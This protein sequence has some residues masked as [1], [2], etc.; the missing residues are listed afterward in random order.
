VELLAQ[1]KYA[2]LVLV[3]S[4]SECNSADE[5]MGTLSSAED[6]AKAVQNAGGRFFIFGTKH[7]KSGK[8]YKENTARATCPEGWQSDWYNF[9][10]L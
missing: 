7:W 4:G 10:S 8:C 2:H 3:R 6:C 5:D 1:F 9:Y